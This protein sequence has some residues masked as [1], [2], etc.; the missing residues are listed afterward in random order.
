MI[1]VGGRQLIVFV[2]HLRWC[3]L[4]SSGDHV[5]LPLLRASSKYNLQNI[6]YKMQIVSSGQ[7]QLSI[8]FRGYVIKMQLLM[9]RCHLVENNSSSVRF[10]IHHS[11]I[12]ASSTSQSRSSLQSNYHHDHQL[13]SRPLWLPQTCINQTKEDHPEGDGA[14]GQVCPPSFNI[15]YSSNWYDPGNRINSYHHHIYFFSVALGS[16]NYPPKNWDIWSAS[17]W[18]TSYLLF[19]CRCYIWCWSCFIS[20]S[21][22]RRH[23][24]GFR[25]YGSTPPSSSLLLASP[26]ITIG[27]TITIMIILAWLSSA[28]L[29]LASHQQRLRLLVSFIW[30]IWSS[31]PTSSFIWPPPPPQEPWTLEQANLE[32]T[33]VRFRI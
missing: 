28:S 12:S 11:L 21:S 5:K 30:V 20:E 3:H 8:R 7:Q 14:F 24:L 29:S 32:I 10:L 26:A 9:F 23:Q 15:W 25:I 16:K 27:A 33:V 13:L 19:D 6:K 31:A 17:L 1:E 18:S 22:G 4:V 2:W